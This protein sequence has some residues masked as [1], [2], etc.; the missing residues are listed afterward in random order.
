MAGTKPIVIAHRGAC[1]YAPEH[2]LVAKALG[3][4]MG[5]DFIEQ[6]IVLTRDDQPIVLHDIH[7]DTV[8]DV[9]QLFPGR[10]RADGRYYAID[11]L[12][13]E[14][15]QLKVHERV[16]WSTDKVIYPNRFPVGWSEFRVP[17]FAEEIELIQ[18]LNASTGGTVGIYPE[19]KS[20][21]W[22]RQQGKDISRIV[23]Q[24]LDQYGYHDKSDPVYLQCFEVDETRRL[25]EQGVVAQFLHQLPQ[26]LLLRLKLLLLLTPPRFQHVPGADARLRFVEGAVEVHHPDLQGPRRRRDPQQGHQQPEHQMLLFH[27]RPALHS[28]HESNGLAGELKPGST[29]CPCRLALA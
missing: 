18:G 25:R 27:E 16:D 7:L 3:Y 10:A 22:H 2:T 23:L 26:L 8:T 24:V 19:I 9:A 12:L 14:I 5:A 15:R 4:A 28:A 17:T 21:G 20:P 29:G 13:E 6:D 11:F 1:G